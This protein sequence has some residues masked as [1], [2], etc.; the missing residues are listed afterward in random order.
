MFVGGGAAS[1]VGAAF[2]KANVVAAVGK[3]AGG[4]ESG[5]SATDDGDGAG[6]LV[7]H[8]PAPDSS[9]NDA[10]KENLQEAPGE[11]EELLGCGDGNSRREDVVVV[12]LDALEQGVIN[13]DQ[14]PE[15]RTGVGGDERQQRL[16]RFVIVFGTFCFSVEQSA[17][18]GGERA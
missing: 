9:R 7:D 1:N 11:D 16:A 6:R 10:V 15:G 8:F 5:E 2:E 13:R 12:P 18:V 3:G 14:H 4:G 17:L